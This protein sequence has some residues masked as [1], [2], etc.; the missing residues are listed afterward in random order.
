MSR[1]AS[2]PRRST[3]GRRLLAAT[4]ASLA[5]HTLLFHGLNRLQLGDITPSPLGEQPTSPRPRPP[6]RQADFSLRVPKTVT[7]RRQAFEQPLQL[8]MAQ[9]AVPPVR[10]TPDLS[11][12]RPRTSP[13]QLPDQAQPIIASAAR[14]PEQQQQPAAAQSLDRQTAKATPARDSLSTTATPLAADLAPVATPFQPQAAALPKRST[15][16]SEAVAGQW[17]PREA[18]LLERL[19]A[20]TNPRPDRSNPSVQQPIVTAAPRPG[21]PTVPVPTAPSGV[22]AVPLPEAAVT[23]GQQ[24]TNQFQPRPMTIRPRLSGAITRPAG[25]QTT[26]SVAG[27]QGS[28]QAA[29]QAATAAQQART[30]TAGRPERTSSPLSGRPGSSAPVA[31]GL[32]RRSDLVAIADA[33]VTAKRLATGDGGRARA[34]SGAGTAST[35]QPAPAAGDRL[36]MLATR[37]QAITTAR[38]RPAENAAGD[39]EE[40]LSVSL[41]QLRSSRSATELAEPAVRPAGPSLA[42]IAAAA[43]PADGRVRDVAD[44]FAGRL[45][46]RR[47]AAATAK[48]ADRE[49]LIQADAMIERG[50]EFL[51][52]SQQA[53]GRW[54]L[55]HAAGST[56]ADAPQLTCDTAATGLALLSFLGAGHDH[57][58]GP[59]R[60]VV[61]RGIEWLLAVQQPNGD[62]YLQAD[63][64][65]NSCGWLYSHAIATMALCEA[66][67]MTGDPLVR[68]AAEKACQF[69]TASQHISG[70]WRYL[71]GTDSDLSVSGWMLVALRAGALAGIPVAPETFSGVQNFVERSASAVDP[72]RYTYNPRDSQQRQ[73]PLSVSCM[74]AVGALM[75]LHTG[76]RAGDRL[77]ARPADVLL[78]DAPNYG[79]AKNRRRDAYPWYYASQVLVHTGGERWDRW[80]RDLVDLLSEHQQRTGQAAGSWDPLGSQP[81]RW[82][83]YGGRIYVTTLH[84][85]AL[86]VPARHLPTYSVAAQE[87]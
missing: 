71:P 10:P 79:S 78:A 51:A 81:D 32:A 28:N 67:G 57:F 76:V 86:E 44:A 9:P 24:S 65:S 21:R 60:D 41:E 14:T 69:I 61:R 63:P 53:D 20:G 54:S 6:K 2:P 70:G 36:A 75:R 42:R 31:S 46:D 35:L 50:L 66:V 73:S 12:N 30:A 22:K 64:L 40:G 33:P 52:R 72:T 82:G 43:L 83:H 15:A 26:G 11:A 74:T 47:M 16:L 5:L 18:L 48:V 58:A 62:L 87:P 19:A 85:L 23:A 68:P 4:V 3:A 8:P 13:R 55:T 1:P 17:R 29:E 25:S 38:G 7:S 56:P 80:Y 59:Y 37:G 27:M 77:V 45:A 39:A 49:A 34:T 84:L